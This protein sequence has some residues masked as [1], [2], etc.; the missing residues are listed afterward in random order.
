M[1]VSVIIKRYDPVKAGAS[2]K[3]EHRLYLEE[4]ARITILDVLRKIRDHKDGSLAFRCSCRSGICGSCAVR[5]NGR[6]ALACTTGLM[7]SLN[8]EGKVVIEPLKNLTAIKDLVVDLTPMWDRLKKSDP[9]L[10][11]EGASELGRA[12]DG[13]TGSLPPSALPRFHAPI[14]TASGCILCGACYSDCEAFKV[15]PDFLGPAVFNKAYRFVIDPRDSGGK[16][17]LKKL[18][19]AGLWH[20]AH[21]YLCASICPKGIIP[22]DSISY[23][24]AKSYRI[25]LKDDPGASYID[26]FYHG[27]K[28]A[29]R[30]SEPLLAFKVKGIGIL[31]EIPY[32]LK[33]LTHGKVPRIRGPIKGIKEIKKIYKI[34][35]NGRRG[36]A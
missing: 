22:K 1:D 34:I 5:V 17:R 35:E 36:K 11:G 13:K 8:K 16:D 20:C 26:G 18:A 23:L 2:Y 33:L 15:D 32:F 19:D 9:W 14:N 12:E 4:N 21:C 25:G 10:I 31:K 3:E 7:D 6:E 29:G 28:R 30:I 27:I 24:R